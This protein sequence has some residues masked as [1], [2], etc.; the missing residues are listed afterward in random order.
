KTL[1]KRYLALEIIKCRFDEIDN[2]NIEDLRAEFNEYPNLDRLL[3][4]INQLD[5]QRYDR[6][7][8]E[9]E[10]HLQMSNGDIYVVSNQ[11]GKGNIYQLIE[12][13]ANF[14]YEIINTSKDQLKR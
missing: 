9:K 2:K 11:W 4:K 5:E 8:I 6:Y 7:F 10:H 12:I 3:V 14:N 13:A 1:N